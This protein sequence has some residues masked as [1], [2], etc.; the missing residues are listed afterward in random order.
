VSRELFS[1][2]IIKTGREG[3]ELREL[4]GVL[5]EFNENFAFHFVSVVRVQIWPGVIFG[6]AR[7]SLGWSSDFSLHKDSMFSCSLSPMLWCSDLKFTVIVLATGP[8]RAVLEFFILP[9]PARV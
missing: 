2:P 1:I 7:W 5:L 8:C 4:V 3:G 9:D 6:F